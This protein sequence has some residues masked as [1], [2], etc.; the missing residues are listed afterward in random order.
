MFDDGKFHVI[1]A[2]RSLK[3]FYRG[4]EYRRR[5]G[6]DQQLCLHRKSVKFIS[7]MS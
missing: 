3:Y 1:P 4:S 6:F 2:V 5:V 7:E